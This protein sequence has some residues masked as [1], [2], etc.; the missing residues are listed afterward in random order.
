MED[1]T[2]HRLEHRDS[3]WWSSPISCRTW[4]QLL[5]SPLAE[6]RLHGEE[7]LEPGDLGIGDP[8]GGAQHGG[9]SGSLHHL[10]LRAHVDAGE[11]EGQQVLW[12]T[13]EGNL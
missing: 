2:V 11:A 12:K 5:D 6:R 7:V 3:S 13:P 9:G 10:Q 4:S 1:V 8:A